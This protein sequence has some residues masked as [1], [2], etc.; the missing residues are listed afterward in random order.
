MELPIR[1]IKQRLRRWRQS[2]RWSTGGLWCIVAE[3]SANLSPL[4]GGLLCRDAL[5]EN[6]RQE[7][8]KR[9]ARRAKTKMPKLQMRLLDCNMVRINDRRAV[10]ETDEARSQFFRDVLAFAKGFYNYV[11]LLRIRV[12][13]CRSGARAYGSPEMS[14]SEPSRRVKRPVREVGE[15]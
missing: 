5:P 3:S 4:S 15:R 7:F 1:N 11:F 9:I 13:E 2:Q 8:M 14:L 10:S 6:C 12:Q